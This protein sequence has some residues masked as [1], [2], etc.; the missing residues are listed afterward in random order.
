MI[1][2]LIIVLWTLIMAFNFFSGASGM[3]EDDG[4]VTGGEA[5]VLI[6]VNGF[7]WALIVVPTALVGMIFRKRREAP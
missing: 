6:V 2:K 4:T 7:L 3:A 5:I 1:S